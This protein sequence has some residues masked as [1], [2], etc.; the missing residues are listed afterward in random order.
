MK[1]GKERTS[2]INRNKQGRSNMKRKDKADVDKQ[3]R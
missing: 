1:Y 2:Q 3:G